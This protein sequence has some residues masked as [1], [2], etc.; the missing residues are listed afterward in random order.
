MMSFH[1][2]IEGPAKKIDCFVWK[3]PVWSVIWA[4][5]NY[6]ILTNNIQVQIIK[7]KCDAYTIYLYI[8]SYLHVYADGEDGEEWG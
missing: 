8:H 4:N 2:I 5:L 1:V 3:N 6:I 7:E